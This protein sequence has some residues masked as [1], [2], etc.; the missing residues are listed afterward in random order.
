MLDEAPVLTLVVLPGPLVADGF[1][2]AAL[3][4]DLE[5]DLVAGL[6]EVAAPVVTV[7]PDGC[8]DAS[9]A[10]TTM[11]TAAAA[12]KRKTN[13]WLKFIVKALPDKL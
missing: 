11:S 7:P 13:C 4:G 10:K 3:P 1:R 6:V 5:V 8:P 2:G 9:K 12:M